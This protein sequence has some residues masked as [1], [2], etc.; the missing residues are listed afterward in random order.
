MLSLNLY[1]FQ[2]LPGAT[3][4]EDTKRSW[5]KADDSSILEIPVK[6]HGET[7]VRHLVST[8]E[9]QFFKEEAYRV[10]REK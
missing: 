4:I 3:G 10:S 9:K 1:I 7:K 6:G 5:R 8:S 2:R